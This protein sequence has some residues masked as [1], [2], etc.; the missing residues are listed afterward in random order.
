MSDEKQPEEGKESKKYTD[1]INKLVALLNGNDL[2]TRSR[3]PNGEV[4]TAM[5]ELVKEE[6]AFRIATVKEDIK[7]LIKKKMEFDTLHK[8]KKAEFE[9]AIE[10]AQ[11]SFN[12][13]ANKIFS[14]I[15]DIKEI[16]EKYLATLTST[17]NSDSS[18]S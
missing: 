8:Q 17:S 6:K 16:E 12:Q 7:I 18:A 5:Q 2:L 4:F 13:E 1:N 11:K 9:K 3:M 14:K 15:E 10:E